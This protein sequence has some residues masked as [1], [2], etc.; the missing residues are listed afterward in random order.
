QPAL[1]VIEYALAQLW[2]AWGLRPAAMIGHSIGEYVAAC[3]AGVFSLEDALALVA[4]RGQLMQS[5]PRGAMLSVPLPETEVKKLLNQEL[6]LAV[7]NAPSLC[8]VSG[9][10]DAVT[11]L[12]NRLTA[13]NIEC[14]WLHTS[15][16]FHSA[17][18][19]PILA[20]FTAH[21]KKMRLNPPQMPYLSNVSGTWIT[22]AQATE[23]SYWARHLRHT[24]RF[25]EGLQE[26]LKKPEY[27]LLEIGPGR[28]LTTLVQRHPQKAAEQV[29]L[30]SVRHPKDHQAD[31]SFLLTTLGK[32][33]LAGVS[34][35]WT[36]FYAQEQRQRLPLPTYP[37]ERQ[38]YW[39]E[40][41]S[42]PLSGAIAEVSSVPKSELVDRFY[43]PT[44][45][46][47][48]APRY[49]PNQT[50]AHMNWLVFMDECGLGTLLVKRL[51]QANIEVISVSTG[52]TFTQLSDRVYTLNPHQANDYEVLFNELARRD[53]LP[54]TIIHLWSVTSDYQLSD[55]NY[56]V[57]QQLGF[58]SLLFIARTL[59]K[60]SLK[61]KFQIEVVSNQI[62]AVTG[63]ELLYPEKATVLG[64]VKVIPQE[65]P[66]IRCRSIDIV[67]PNARS[68]QKLIDQ[69][70]A[71]FTAGH[72]NDS[73]P[74]AFRGP[75]RWEQSFAAQRLE[76][77]TDNTIGLRK[78][79]VYLITGGL[80]GLGLI[81]AE[82]LA[83]TVQARLVLVSRS[84]L[85][86]REEWARLLSNDNMPGEAPHSNI[87]LNMAVK[88]KA[89]NQLEAAYGAEVMVLSADVAD[90]VQMQAAYT[91]ATARFGEIHG[92]IHA[93][94]I[95]GGGMIQVKAVEMAEREFAP[96]IKGTRTLETIFKNVKLDFMVLCSSLLAILGR[97]G[98]VGY[99]AA[100]AFLD[101]FVHYKTAESGTFVV[102][103]N[104][105][106]WQNV[107]M[108]ARVE[109]VHQ[110][111]TGE[112]LTGGLTAD[113]GT[114]AFSRILSSIGTLQQIIVSKR[115]VIYFVKEIKAVK[116]YET[117]TLPTTSTHSRPNLQNA[118]VAPRFE[119]EQLV[120]N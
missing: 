85:P 98:Q 18:M 49:Q 120:A 12:E 24:V 19:E 11:A 27:A 36:G 58:Y 46:R 55:N 2:M 78:N 94:A 16:A 10:T 42:I 79:G 26:L 57:T 52:T 71:E 63:E 101:A 117:E 104:W 112:L 50:L 93:A 45:Q 21:V 111:K 69:L 47:A 7:H 86:R 31:V 72:E 115:N 48:M 60:H 103:I 88:I 6:S 118:Y 119:M 59:E 80:G 110:A 53:K 77:S 39:I 32:L 100:N 33:W 8:A 113:E 116:L 44:W 66:N 5:L 56:Q 76:K 91:Q 37:F 40:Q 75:Y 73:T 3:L 74:I 92:V 15:H 84:E 38:R 89:I 108:L 34:I 114:D 65:C 9:T 51:E 90:L 28:T 109:A 29:A 97:K 35:D 30:T 20:S 4:V 17:M 99:C 82:Y 64:P 107:G 23:P 68:R 1:F 87:M 54:Q 62:Q 106:R 43:I 67:L 105:G 13:Q 41:K 102:S 81:F 83:K 96:K 14:L 95:E 22:A 25:A 70:L 61:N